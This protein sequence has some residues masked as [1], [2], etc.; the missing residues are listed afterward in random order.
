MNAFNQWYRDDQE[1]DGDDYTAHMRRETNDVVMKSHRRTTIKRGKTPPTNVNGIH[2][3][4]NKRVA[5]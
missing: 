5:W 1:D 4:R 3:R 2:R